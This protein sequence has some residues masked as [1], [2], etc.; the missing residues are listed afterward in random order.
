MIEF[1]HES[2]PHGDE[3]C[4]Y[5]VE[6]SEGLTLRNFLVELHKYASEHKEW[7]SVYL[8]YSYDDQII[9]YNGRQNMA[10]LYMGEPYM[11]ADK[12]SV[13]YENS[14]R[15]YNKY[16]DRKIV[17]IRANGGWGSMNYYLMMDWDKTGSIIEAELDLPFDKE[18]E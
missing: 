14:K 13:V 2:G 17:S 1:I 7:G 6:F 8:G 9:E 5:T 18:R 4:W 10:W 11:D 16:I 3:T 12:K 15:L